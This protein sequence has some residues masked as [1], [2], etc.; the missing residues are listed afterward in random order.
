MLQVILLLN[1]SLYLEALI[2]SGSVESVA[3]VSSASADYTSQGVSCV[4]WVG[5][6]NIMMLYQLF[7]DYAVT[8]HCV[9][10]AGTYSQI[11]IDN[12]NLL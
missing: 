5:K 6:V 9:T 12:F 8:I 10:T 4:A 3:P 11:I 2:L 7:Y 1:S